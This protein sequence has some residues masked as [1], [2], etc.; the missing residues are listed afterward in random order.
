M[1]LDP[2]EEVDRGV[3]IGLSHLLIGD[4]G[5]EIAADAVELQIVVRRAGVGERAGVAVVEEG[6]DRRLIG[7]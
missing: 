4:A 2:A 1:V 5:E 7:D 6:K 3:V